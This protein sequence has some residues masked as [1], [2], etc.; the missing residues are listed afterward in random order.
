MAMT[1][2]RRYESRI[3]LKNADLVC[4][5]HEMELQVYRDARRRVGG[6]F[7]AFRDEIRYKAVSVAYYVIASV[8]FRRTVEAE[9]TF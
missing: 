8:T 1:E 5:E 6:D 4:Y 7:R 9:T 3:H 2:G